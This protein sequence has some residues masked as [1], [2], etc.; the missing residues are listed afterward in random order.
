MKTK[1]SLIGVLASLLLGA[2]SKSIVLNDYVIVKPAAATATEA[3]AASEL[4]KYL[5]EISGAELPVVSDTAPPTDREIL[6]G[7]TNRLRDDSLARFGEDG[8]V[9]RTDGKRLAIYGGPRHGAL[10]GVY[11][12]LEKYFGCRK[13]T[14]EPVAV[15]HTAKLR[16]G[17]PLDDEQIPQI[18]SRYTYTMPYDSLYLDWHKLN[19][20]L[21]CRIS[22]FGLFVHTFNT[23]LPPEKYYAQHPEYYAM[24]KGRRVATQPCLSNPQVLEIVCDELS[25]RIAAN[26]EAKYWSVSANDNYGYCTCPECAKI[27]A[28]EESPAGSVVRFANKVAA[29]FPNKTISTLGYLYSRK[30]PKTKPAPNVNIMFCSIECDRHMPIADDPGSAD[31]RRDMEAWAA[32]TDNIFVWDYCGSFKEL[33][34]PTPGFGVMQSN[35]QYFVRNGVKIFFEQ[36]SGPMGSEFHQLRGYLAA[37]LLWDPELDFDATMND[38]LNGYYGAAGPIIR[39]YIDLLRQNREASGEPF[40]IFNYTTD[41]AGSWLAPDKLRGYLAILD[42]AEAAVAGDTTLLRRVHYTRQPVQFAQLEL[43]RT[44]P[45][46]PEGYLE[47]VGGRWQVKREWLDKLHDFVTSYKL[48]GVKNVCEWHNEPDSYL[49]QMLRSAQVEQVDNLAFGKPVRASVPVA[50]NRNPQGQGTQLLTDGVRGTEIYRSQWLGYYQPEV[51]FYID[52]DTVQP[53]YH[54]DASFLQILWESAFLPESVEVYTSTDGKRYQTAGR[55]TNTVLREPFFGIKQFDC[56][57][58]PRPVRYVRV[59]VKAMELCPAWHYYAGDDALFFID[60]IVVRKA[61]Y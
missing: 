25:R 53:V 43:S 60:E 58:A 19:H 8:F 36:C 11:T 48:N 20:E 45:Y 9:I 29:R 22:E 40:G 23:L 1:L 46:G 47:E 28:E 52:L 4:Q 18:T 24:V 21:D 12:L 57:F 7:I 51:D 55:Q 34:M 16:I 5:F 61:D 14:A 13:Y 38:F 30:A 49:R 17:V 41:F 10:Y 3:K 42:R 15:P 54:V 6:I 35:I 44:D 32:L 39:E 31:F 37:K 2:C 59:R 33:Q 26:P 27:D 50:E 56:D